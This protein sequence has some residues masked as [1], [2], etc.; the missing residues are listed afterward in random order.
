MQR[1]GNIAVD[2]RFDLDIDIEVEIKSQLQGVF[3]WATGLSHL[4]RRC[5]SVGSISEQLTSL[6]VLLNESLCLV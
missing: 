1:E 2:A 3:P 6:R 4:T 5:A